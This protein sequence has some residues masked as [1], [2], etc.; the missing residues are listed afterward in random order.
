MGVLTR[1]IHVSYSLVVVVI[2]LSACTVEN[3]PMDP[4]DGDRV[5]FETQVQPILT[6][7]CAFLGCHGREGM[8]LT[9]Y[10]V[11]FLRMRDPEGKID[12]TRPVLNEFGLSAAEY[13]HNQTALAARVNRTDPNGDLLINRLIPQD[14]G[15]IYHAG[16]VVYD[17]PEDPQL[18]ILRRFL[19][20]IR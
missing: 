10:S 11:D 2:I 14:Q 7:Q 3:P 16:V 1:S 13:A 17:N 20:A 19:E 8:P 5:V 4:Y 18:E 9:I 12:P 6:Q 15:G